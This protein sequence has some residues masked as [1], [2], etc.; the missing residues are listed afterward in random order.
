MIW[1]LGYLCGLTT[2]IWGQLPVIGETGPYLQWGALGILAVSTAKLF[3]ELGLQRKDNAE[4]RKQSSVVIGNL[5]DRWE[6]WEKVRHSD[7]E[8]LTSTLVQLREN[9]A[10]VNAGKK[11]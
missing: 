5:C 6:E 9:C 1:K 8:S 7:H 10:T 4:E 2:L 11:G 3:T